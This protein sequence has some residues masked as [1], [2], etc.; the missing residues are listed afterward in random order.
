M[1][2]M[3]QHWRTWS[4]PSFQDQLNNMDKQKSLV[5][6]HMLALLRNGRVLDKVNYCNWLG[7]CNA[8]VA[9]VAYCYMM[10]RK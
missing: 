6:P 4:A 1:E 9:V 2:G 10:T 5:P 8:E 3:K 7:H